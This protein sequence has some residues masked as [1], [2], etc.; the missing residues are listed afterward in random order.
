[1]T[2]RRTFRLGRQAHEGATRS[3]VR[4]RQSYQDLIAGGES[5]SHPAWARPSRH[6]APIATG[7]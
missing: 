2:P 7:S 4:V 1:L 5:R 6:P 3:P